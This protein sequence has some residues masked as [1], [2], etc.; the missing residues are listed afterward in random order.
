[1][2]LR[3][4][5]TGVDSASQE[6]TLAI[7]NQGAVI[8]GSQL[9][10]IATGDL[11]ALNIGNRWSAPIKVA[12]DRYNPG[13]AYLWRNLDRIFIQPL[14]EQ[15]KVEDSAIDHIFGDED[16]ADAITNPFPAEVAR[17]KDEDPDL[18]LPDTPDDPPDEEG[19]DSVLDR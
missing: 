9:H 12:D 18:A 3:T 6:H 4:R 13:H 2:S 14:V 8:N 16:V 5:V 10:D 17:D 1:M 15:H 19:D 11:I 7:C